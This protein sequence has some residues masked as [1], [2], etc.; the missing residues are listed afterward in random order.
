MKS[1]YIKGTFLLVAIAIS[2]GCGSSDGDNATELAGNG[3]IANADDGVPESSVIAIFEGEQL[4]LADGWQDAKSCVV[5]QG[6]T[7]CFRSHADA[8]VVVAE[9]EADSVSIAMAAPA[10]SQAA[11]SRSCL[12]LYQDNGFQGRHLTF[13]DR[14]YWQNLGKYDFNDKLSSYKTGDYGVHL[15]H[16]AGGNG[17]W[18]PGDTSSCTSSSQMSSGWNDEVSAIYIR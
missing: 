8:D 2:C 11:C 1:T 7:E 15:S 17:Y 6:V 16:D 5:W 12:H 13:C 10:P 3:E 18:Y 4:R 14:G 9:I